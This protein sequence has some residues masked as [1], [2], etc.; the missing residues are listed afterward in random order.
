[1]DNQ[2]SFEPELQGRPD[3]SGSDSQGKQDTDQTLFIIRIRLF[4]KYASG[5]DKT[6]GS[7]RTRIRNPDLAVFVIHFP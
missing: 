7:D 3:P 2:Y 4:S 5:S 1:M 6:P